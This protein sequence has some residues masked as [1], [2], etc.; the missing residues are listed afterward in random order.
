MPIA[1]ASDVDAVRLRKKGIARDNV[2]RSG[3]STAAEN[4]KPGLSFRF[5]IP[6]GIWRQIDPFEYE[7]WVGNEKPPFGGKLVWIAPENR[8]VR[9]PP[10]GWRF[11]REAHAAGRGSNRRNVASLRCW[12]SAMTRPAPIA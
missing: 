4:E 5:Q 11:R 9:R 6:R 2:E 8:P 3:D 7:V 1:P 12:S 10:P